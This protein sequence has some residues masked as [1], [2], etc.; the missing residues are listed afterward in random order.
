MKRLLTAFV[1]LALLAST[2]LAVVVP[3]VG[4]GYFDSNKPRSKRIA[5]VFPSRSRLS[6]GGY[7]GI[8]RNMEF[9]LTPVL[10]MARRQGADVH[11]YDDTWFEDW[12]PTGTTATRNQRRQLWNSIGDYYSLVIVPY[13]HVQTAA[14]SRYVC[15]DSTNGQILVVAGP[16]GSTS[17]ADT[18][19]RGHVDWS[20]IHQ[21][22]GA[23]NN[24][25]FVTYNPD[26]TQRDTIT[27][28]AISTGKRIF[29]LPSGI[30]SVVRLLHPLAGYSATGVANLVST[31]GA[32][33]LH[34]F[35][36][37]Y[38]DSVAI[39][40]NRAD[41]T[42]SVSTEFLGPIW[43]VRFASAVATATLNST[44][45]LGAGAPRDVFW[46]KMIDGSAAT[47]GTYYHSFLWAL[48]CRFV[49]VAPIKIAYEADDAF[50]K[51]SN[52]LTAR[53]GGTNASMDSTIARFRRYGIVWPSLAVNPDH[54]VSYMAGTN[55][56]YEAAWTASTG[57]RYPRTHALPWVH[58]AH[59]TTSWVRNADVT[60]GGVALGAGNDEYTLSGNL[61]G[62][63]GGYNN[64]NDFNV[65]QGANTNVTRFTD[66]VASRW[67]PHGDVLDSTQGDLRHSRS[68]NAFRAGIVQRLARSDSLRRRL[69]PECPLPPYLNFPNNEILPINYK[70]NRPSRPGGEAAWTM[71]GTGS[72]DSLLIP[73]DSLFW[74]FDTMLVNRSNSGREKLY[75]RTSLG[76]PRQQWTGFDR[77]S[78]PAF[79]PFLYPGE[80]LSLRVRGRL[81]QAV[82][83]NS[84]LQGAGGRNSQYT[85]TQA[86][87]SKLL[88]LFNPVIHSMVSNS[89]FAPLGNAETYAT[90]VNGMYAT[91]ANPQRSA[92]AEMGSH[93]VYQHP[94]SGGFPDNGAGSY[95]ADEFI[96]TY[97]QGVRA[98][99]RIAGRAPAVWVRPWQVLSK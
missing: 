44:N 40:H 29:A 81:V 41:S 24:A 46:C 96:I 14:K 67:N 83:I 57:A 42:A 55:P 50:D 45:D 79:T 74:A 88:G 12:S 22:V 98:L 6:A 20:G 27:T 76:A 35:N 78:F 19:I 10:D 4:P 71:Y 8:K 48:I 11:W 94:V 43:R 92:P 82:C 9:N 60:R 32:E 89:T 2:A 26:A 91:S 58:H 16:A 51:A 53:A 99:T 28:F 90:D 93:V 52:N 61:V 59:D 86:R 75:L 13:P 87:I 39:T 36:P 30:D 66:R 34:V 77:D 56:V 72:T 18:T 5:V 64:G 68:L 63:F 84:F 47:S 65:T 80:R 7:P 25:R 97:G 31:A 62:R 49:D 1:L 38:G 37:A 54:A 70:K 69:C 95:D 33:S 73:I 23:T 3:T 85:N 17:W 21:V 15:A